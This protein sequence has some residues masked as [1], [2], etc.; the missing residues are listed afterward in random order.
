MDDEKPGMSVEDREFIAEMDSECFRDVD[1][2]WTAPLPF[3]PNRQTLP[4]NREQAMKRTLSLFAS[5]KRDPVKMDHALTFMEKGLR[6]WT[7]GRS[8][9]TSGWRRVLVCADLWSV[10]SKETQ[11]DSHGI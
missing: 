2:R 5:F 9:S 3:K 1:G 7:C 4:N 11:S 8:T 10:P 6:E